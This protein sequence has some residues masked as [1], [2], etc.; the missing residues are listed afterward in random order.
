MNKISLKHETYTIHVVLILL[1]KKLVM[2]LIFTLTI[3][4]TL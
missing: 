2:I 1:F 4:L 3:S